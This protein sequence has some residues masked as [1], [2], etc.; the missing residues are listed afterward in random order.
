MSRKGDGV[1]AA[2]TGL[3]GEEEEEEEEEEESLPGRSLHSINN[4]FYFY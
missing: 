3:R 4:L 1:L 2:S